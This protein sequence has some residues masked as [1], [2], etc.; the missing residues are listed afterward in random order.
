VSTKGG[1]ALVKEHLG[2]QGGIDNPLT[3]D[4]VIEK[5]HW[6]SEAF[7][8]EQLRGRLI[9]AVDQLDTQPVSHLLGLLAQVR[10]TPAY[11]RTHRGIQ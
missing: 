10:P 4:Q 7:A 6:L 9:D 5:F 8:D 1:R 11:A 3:W 2:Y